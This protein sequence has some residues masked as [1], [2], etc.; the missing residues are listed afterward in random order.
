MLMHFALDNKNE[1]S[2]ISITSTFLVDLSDFNSTLS[3]YVKAITVPERKVETATVE[4]QFRV[5]SFH[6]NKLAFDNISITFFDDYNFTVRKYFMD[7]LL[8]TIFDLENGTYKPQSNYKKTIKVYIFKNAV[9]LS[10]LEDVTKLSSLETPILYWYEF[11]G[12]FPTEV[13]EISFNNE[14]TEVTLQINFAYDFY[15]VIQNPTDSG[16][17]TLTIDKVSPLK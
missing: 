2:N 3:K 5:G 15:K 14:E 17:Q 9:S 7:Y 6:T 12:V 16:K 13:P 8:T 11:Y 4:G 10:N 1:I